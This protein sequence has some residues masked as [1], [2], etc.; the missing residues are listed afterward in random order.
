MEWLKNLFSEDARSYVA[1]YVPGKGSDIRAHENYLS[2][3]VHV[4][5]ITKVRKLTKKFYGAVHGSVQIQHE[6]GNPREFQLFDTL[7]KMKE[8]DPKNL[9]RIIQGPYK[10]LKSAPRF[11]P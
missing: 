7:G 10:L 1:G 6:D 5:K 8:F 2:I 3:T 11:H 9:D 4:L